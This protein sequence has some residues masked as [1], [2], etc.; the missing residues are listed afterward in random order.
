VADIVKKIVDTVVRKSFVPTIVYDSILTAT[1]SPDL[2]V[3]QKEMSTLCHILYFD[4]FHWS[5]PATYK[6]K[7]YISMVHSEV[8][9]V[10]CT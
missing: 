5:Q 2:H 8:L 3:F 6:I 9:I 4:T 1:C 7:I 10:N